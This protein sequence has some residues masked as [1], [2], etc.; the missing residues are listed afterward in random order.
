MFSRATPLAVTAVVSIVTPDEIDPGPPAAVTPTPSCDPTDP[1]IHFP[2]IELSDVH[3]VL[4]VAVPSSRNR[5]LRSSDS[6][7]MLDPT[8]VTLIDPVDAVFAVP[9]PLPTAVSYDWLTVIVAVCPHV[10]VDTG[11]PQ[12]SPEAVLLPI[13]VSDTHRQDSLPL[14]PSRTPWLNRDD[15]LP[16]PDPMTVTLVAPVDAEFHALIPLPAPASKLKPR[17]IDDVASPLVTA[18]TD[19]APTPPAIFPRTLLSDVHHVPAASLPAIRSREL[20]AK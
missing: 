6:D 14:S 20:R 10:V 12:P 11:H 18:I 17:V 13:A 7:P 15:E 3:C 4:A 8:T 9:I 16:S 2:R 19:P 5:T 1:A